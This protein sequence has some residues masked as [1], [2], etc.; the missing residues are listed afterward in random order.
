MFVAVYVTC[1]VFIQDKRQTMRLRCPLPSRAR[2]GP[3]SDTASLPPLDSRSS[4]QSSTSSGGKAAS[5]KG[6]GWRAP[7][8]KLEKKEVSKVV[9]QSQLESAKRL[10]QGLSVAQIQSQTTRNKY[11]SSN[12]PAVLIMDEYDSSIAPN[13]QQLTSAGNIWLQSRLQKYE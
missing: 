3:G 10:S 7:P 6:L 13:Q 9:T 5:A 12:P 2:S 4:S 8:P 1:Q 11:I